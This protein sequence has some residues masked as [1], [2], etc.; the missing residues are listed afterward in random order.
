MSNNELYK[1]HSENINDLMRYNA[2]E[3]KLRLASE[4]NQFYTRQKEVLMTIDTLFDQLD[5]TSAISQGEA[6][7][8]FVE[9]ITNIYKE[10]GLLSID[11]DMNRILA[12]KF[13]LIISEVNRGNTETCNQSEAKG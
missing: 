1:T 10:A 2:N 13:N 3:L 12:D 7:S 8:Y 5:D 4:A 6:I 9:T 11:I